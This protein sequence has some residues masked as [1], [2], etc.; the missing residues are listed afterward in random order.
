[1]AT[2]SYNSAP[3][4]VGKIAPGTKNDGLIGRAMGDRAP[5]KDPSKIMVRE[6]SRARPAKGK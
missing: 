1:M 4:R 5:K 2:Q 3:A 6:H